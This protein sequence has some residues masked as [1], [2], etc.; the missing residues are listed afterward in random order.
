MPLPRNLTLSNDER[1]RLGSQLLRLARRFERALE[2]KLAP[3]HMAPSHYEI[4]KL[5]YAAPDYALRHGALAQA[6]GITL[7]SV[8]VA[9]RKL[10][11]LGLV[12]QRLGQDRREHYAT[13]SV[14]GA[15]LL[16][17]LYDAS[18]SFANEVFSAIAE[19]DARG[20]DRIISALLARLTLRAEHQGP[21]T[22]AGVTAAAA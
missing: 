16:S 18:E 21:K 17:H 6:L 1:S 8:T 11:S 10:T 9:V 7:P 22:P 2:V 20:M 3:W 19:K 5:L 12:A 4:L 14:K 15:E 13:L